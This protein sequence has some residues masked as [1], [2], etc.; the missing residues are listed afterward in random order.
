MASS[1][2][3]HKWR[4]LNFIWRYQKQL[5]LA[6][7]VTAVVGLVVVISMEPG[8]PSMT[9]MDL[10]PA[11]EQQLIDEMI[12]EKRKLWEEEGFPEGGLSLDKSVDV[13]L[14]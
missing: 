4:M 1:Y 7:I 12:R 3:R 9:D 10:S 13:D 6:V 8:I 11:K 5:V 2:M 14:T